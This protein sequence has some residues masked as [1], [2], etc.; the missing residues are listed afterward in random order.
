MA[1]GGDQRSLEDQKA[2][3]LLTMTHTSWHEYRHIRPKH[4]VAGHLIMSDP[5]YSP[6][7]NNSRHL[8][9][10]LP[11][12]YDT[13]GR[14]RHYPVLY[15]HD[16]QN[17]F[18][19]YTSFSGEWQVDETMCRLEDEGYEAIIVGLPNNERRIHEYSPY[20]AINMRVMQG[21]GDDYLRYITDTVKP[22]IDS[23]FRTRPEREFTGIAGSSM[24]GLISLYAYLCHGHT[25]GFAGAFSPAYWFGSS[26]I[27]DTVEHSRYMPGRLYLDIGTDEGGMS[28]QRMRGT[29]NYYVYGVQ[30]LADALRGQGYRDGESF[31]YVE[32]PGAGHTESA[33]ARR[34]PDA[35]RFL[36]PRP[37]EMES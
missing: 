3:S 18:D 30:R 23:T 25:F 29:A 9:V 10:W 27:F 11:N 14:T 2:L 32:E 35:L 16:G 19:A 17:L 20:S 6:Q 7:L 13:T 1:S 33:W 37:W 5:V 34:L 24:G 26:A 36:L 4:T 12:S 28:K 22:L 21:Q 8:L 15:M 31:Q